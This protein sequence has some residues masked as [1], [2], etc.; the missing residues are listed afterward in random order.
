MGVVYRA[1][2]TALNRPVALKMILAGQFASEREVKR[3]RAEAEASARLD[4]PN[5]VPIYEVGEQDGRPFYTM[6]FM[7][8]GTLTERLAARSAPLAPREGVSLLVKIARA[9]HHAHQRAILHRDL[10]PGN[11]LLDTQGEPHVSDFGLAKCLDSADGLT[12][13]GAMLGSPS[14]MSPEQAAGQSERL[15]TASDTYSL[16]AL[17]YQLLT[18]RPPFEAATP[19]ATMKRVMEEEPRIPSAL[20]STVDRDLETICLKCLEKDPQRR[21]ASADALAEELERC[22]RGEPIQALPCSAWAR[23]WKW[24]R[25]RPGV[26]GPTLVAVLTTLALFV[27]QTVMRVR[28]S[29]ANTRL[30]ASLYELR[31]RQADEASRTDDRAISI[32][33]FSQ[34]LRENPN[35]SATAARLLSLLASCNFPVSLVPPLVHEAPVTAMS[36]SPDG[37]YLATAS[38]EGTTRVWNLNSG[39]NEFELA[40]PGRVERCVLCGGRE[41]RL[42]TISEDHTARLWNLRSRQPILEL[43]VANG[44]LAKTGNGRQIALNVRS[45]VVGVL[46]ADSAGWSG[47][48]LASSAEIVCFD[49]SNDGGLLATGSRSEIRLWRWDGGGY[50]PLFAP[51]QLAAPPGE[52]RFSDD[53]RRLGCLAQNKI[54][55][56]NTATGIREREFGVDASSI[57]FLGQT[58][59]IITITGDPA[60]TLGLFDFRTG[61]DCKSPFGHLEFDPHRHASLAPLLLSSR[62]LQAYMPTRV[63]VVDPATGHALTEPFIHDA[64]VSIAEFSPN[65]RIIATGSQDRTVRI[66]SAEM[67]KREPLTLQVGGGVWEAQWSPSGQRLM[68]ISSDEGGTRLQVRDARNGTPLWPPRDLPSAV[69]FAQWAPDGT[70]LGTECQD[71]TARIWNAETGEPISPPLRHNDRLVHC[72]FSPNGD[73]LATATNDRTVRLWDGRTGEALGSALL[74]SGIPLKI[75]FSSDGER[76]ATGCMDGTIRVWSARD[77]KLVLGPLQH[78]GICWVAAFSPDDRWLVS[79]S[80]DCTAQLWDATTGKRAIPPLRHEGPVYWASFSPDG[81]AVATSTQSGLARVWD[82]ASGQP[83]SEVMRHGGGVWFVKWSPDGRFLA[84]T[85]MDGSA[86]VWDARTGHLVSEPFVHQKE[87]RRAEFSP[88]GRQLLTASLD[89]TAKIWELD[90]IRPPVPVPDWL[91]ELAESLVGKRINSKD[92]PE[93]VPGEVFQRVK[94]RIAQAREQ[95]DYYGRWAKWMLEERLERPVKPFRP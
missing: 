71:S 44:R 77:G 39:K 76:I 31:W 6:K 62:Y 61:Q 14:Y 42:L 36:F 49:L 54:W 47:P 21:Y 35:D 73:L 20:N 40:H 74:H 25:R 65:G 70:R 82:T 1:R 37:G 48:L 83:V 33:R 45:N 52:L 29:R 91:P 55:V 57:A 9:V 89:G 66:W 13:S 19:M 67:A 11:I 86:R 88:D 92:A 38:S 2:D 90:F 56:M 32:A 16:G 51:V 68:I 53:G 30:S 46:D 84:T 93:S 43:A 18:G 64:P 69:F 12:V 79:A 41:L 50:Q 78:H 75:A 59:R 7:E 8:G 24:T 3:F 80:S 34:F 63:W 17:L 87:V 23:L 94:E 95:S 85:C 5:I 81:R 58:E 15:T 4:H 27:S 10:K 72:A 60:T 26:A 22:L 28:V